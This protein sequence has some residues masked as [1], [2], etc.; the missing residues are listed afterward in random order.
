MLLPK[1]IFIVVFNGESLSIILES[2]NNTTKFIYVITLT[3]KTK[4]NNW[5]IIIMS[6][7]R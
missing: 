7:Y 3:N 1:M 5:I 6:Q 4:T 2:Q